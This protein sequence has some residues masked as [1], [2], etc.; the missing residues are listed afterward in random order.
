MKRRRILITG[1]NETSRKVL[2]RSLRSG[3][4]SEG[5][6]ATLIELDANHPT[7]G[8][9]EIGFQC[10]LHTEIVILV[11][12]LET[13]KDVARYKRIARADRE[14]SWQHLTIKDSVSG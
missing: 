9:K 14:G 3:F 7:E 2:A 8:N 4:S 12:C 10:S 11:G 5:L 6:R 1:G 13:P